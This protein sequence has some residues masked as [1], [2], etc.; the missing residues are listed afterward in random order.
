MLEY[1]DIYDANK[2]KTGKIIERKNKKK[3]SEGEY[4]ISVHCFIRVE[5]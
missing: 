4:T 5:F 3:V 2:N 1:M